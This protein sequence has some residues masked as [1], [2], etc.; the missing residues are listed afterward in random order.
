MGINIT[1]LQ[2][3]MFFAQ[4][5]KTPPASEITQGCWSTDYT[6]SPSFVLQ[7]VIE[8]AEEALGYRQWSF[9]H[10]GEVRLD[11]YFTEEGG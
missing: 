3:N 1:W 7:V 10:P 6:T 8:K 11:W 4:M 5:A 2:A 9:V